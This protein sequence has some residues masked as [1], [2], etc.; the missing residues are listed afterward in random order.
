[1]NFAVF[2]P[3][4]SVYQFAGTPPPPSVSRDGLRMRFAPPQ[5]LLDDEEELDD[6][7]TLEEELDATDELELMDDDEE[8]L[9][10]AVREKKSVYRY[11]V[12]E[13]TCITVTDFACAG[14]VNATCVL[15]HAMTEGDAEPRF[16]VVVDP[17]MKVM[18]ARRVVCVFAR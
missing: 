3:Q 14:A 2:V 6:D 1:M 15:V 7:V 18:R 16:I 11:P 10:A 5:M 4:L 9:L 13:M 12:L 8:L 17:F